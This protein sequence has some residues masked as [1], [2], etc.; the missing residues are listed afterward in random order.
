MSGLLLQPLQQSFLERQRRD[1]DLLQPL[2]FGIAGDEVEDLG[3]VAG[4][5]R[6]AGEQRQVGVVTRR[7]RMVVAGAEMGVG[8]QLATLAAHHDRNLGVGLQIEETE[9]HLRTG[10]FQLP[11][12]ADVGGLVEAGLQ[13]DQ[14]GDRLAALRRLA[15]CLHDW[16]VLRGAVKGL[17]DRQHVRVAGR[18]L[19]ELHHNLE[20]L[21]GMV[22]Q[23]VL[24]AHGGEDVAVMVAHPLGAAR[25]VRAPAQ[26]GPVID[27]Q[28]G[29][30]GNADDALDLDHLGRADADLLADQPF[31]RRR[32]AGAEIEPDGAA[33]APALER[34][35]EL[36]HQVLGLFLDL[37]IAVAQHPEDAMPGG[38][39][40]REELAQEQSQQRLQGQEADRVTRAVGEPD[41]AVEFRR[42]RDQGAHRL[43][44]GGTHQFEQQ[45]QPLVRDEREGMCR[46]ERQRG[47]HREHLGQ[48]IILQPGAVGAGQ[49]G[50]LDDVDASLG[51][52][53]AQV[54][55]GLLLRLL[56]R[57]R[58]A[59][60]QLQLLGRGPPVGR[61]PVDA[62]PH[63]GP[64]TGDADGVELIEIGRGNRQEPQ[65][66]QH[67]L[68]GVVRRFEDAPVEG[69]PGH[70][71][72]QE[73][74]RGFGVENGAVLLGDR[75]RRDVQ[76]IGSHRSALARAAGTGTG[77]ENLGRH[78][79]GH[80]FLAR[81]RQAVERAHRAL[82]GT[83]RTLDAPRE[84]LDHSRGHL[85]L[86]VG[87][88]FDHQR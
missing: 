77:T 43:A 9:H 11:G 4:M 10:P 17:L 7:D 51:E 86:T 73:P 83:E 64:Q 14:G 53:T 66:F 3:G 12:E 32:R 56:Q 60:D 46:I 31:Q 61:Q 70:L 65:P 30:V 71:A 84:I 41:E 49:F 63:L 40:T 42:N 88:Q 15:Q 20:A 62:G 76:E 52:Q 54:G 47:H 79:P 24:L 35:L 13:L 67:R 27:D 75:L 59:M 37:Q 80:R 2:R 16:A 81:Q 78:R 69:E 38:G 55:P 72:V 21:V 57:P 5:G 34:G 39:V 28:L 45:R 74:L 50:G 26:V 82:D 87:E 1:L 29:D 44:V 36:A 19:Q 85:Q 8:D 6:R 23:H 68:T 33:A 25:L 58:L 48:E 18:L 22:Q